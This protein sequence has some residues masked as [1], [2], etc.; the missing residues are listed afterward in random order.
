[1]NCQVKPAKFGNK[2][3]VV[4]NANTDVVTSPK[5]FKVSP[6]ESSN[7]D[8]PLK[9]LDQRDDYDKVHV[10]VK[11]LSVQDTVNVAGGLQKQ[12]VAIADATSPARITLWESDIG[13]LE[14]G[15]SYRL[16]NIVVRSYQ[17]T[18]YLSL[19]KNKDGVLIEEIKD[20]GDVAEDDL[21]ETANT[22]EGV[23][24][25]GVLSLQNYLSCFVCKAKVQPVDDGMGKC[26]KCEMEQS[27]HLCLNKLN[28]HLL[29]NVPGGSYLTLN[30][31]GTN[32][33][34]IAQREPVTSQ[35]LIRARSFTITHDDNVVTGLRRP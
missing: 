17:G 11:V 27:S 33:K 18:K 2:L 15:L 8:I 3:E 20:I 30:A 25:A 23:T 7:P 22:V 26:T 6:W 28:A 9:D 32:L 13:S 1:M 19:P 14:D 4:I 34:D 24:V 16:T 21:P 31:F 12:D 10:T 5:K 35:D 29:L